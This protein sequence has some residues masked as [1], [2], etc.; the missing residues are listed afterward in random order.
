MFRI[1]ALDKTW[2][3]YFK[4]ELTYNARS[5]NVRPLLVHHSSH[6]K[7]KVIMIT[8]YEKNE[9]RVTARSTGTAEFHRKPL[10]KFWL[11]KFAATSRSLSQPVPWFWTN[12][13]S[14][15][16]VVSDLY[17]CGLQVSSHPSYRPGM[18]PPDFNIFPKIKGQLVWNAAV[19]LRGQWV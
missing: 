5:G 13:R 14:H 1:F 7:I 6:K 17:N 16:N 19:A 10:Q 4:G 3:W 15:I 12:I 9:R 11:Q 8:V 2:V 18:S